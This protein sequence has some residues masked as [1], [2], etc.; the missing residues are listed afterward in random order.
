[1]QQNTNHNPKS[2]HGAHSKAKHDDHSKAKH[3]AHS[4][5]KHGAHSKAKHGA[6]SKGQLF[7]TEIIFSFSLFLAAILVFILVWNSIFS[8]FV[9]DQADRR[10]E[11]SLIGIAD[12]TVL[13]PGDP[14]N[15]ELT[16]GLNANAFGLASSRNVLSSKK[17]SAM[18][19][20]FAS[21]YTLMRTKMGAGGYGLFIEVTDASGTV[22]YN[23]GQ[24]SNSTNLQVSQVTA[25]RLAMLDNQIVNLRVQVW[26]I[27]GTSV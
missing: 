2:K 24:S 15:W 21:N 14:Q 26:R 20:L 10:M 12:M 17:L 27:K 11:V 13:S 4:K 16:S 18:Q 25:E 7:S 22:L 5:A 9:E 8:S 1:M 19:S 23:F 6:H 3:S